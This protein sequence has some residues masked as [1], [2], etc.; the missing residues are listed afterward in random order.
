ML[1]VAVFI[2]AVCVT[3]VDLP[4]VDVSAR[5]L[6]LVTDLREELLLLLLVDVVLLQE[7]LHVLSYSIHHLALYL[8][9]DSAGGGRRPWRSFKFHIKLQFVFTAG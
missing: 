7:V 1:G 9:L 4:V 2:V 5:L 8:T 3:P 6:A